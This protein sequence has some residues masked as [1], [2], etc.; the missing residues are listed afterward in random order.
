M[1]PPETD[2]RAYAFVHLFT[3]THVQ[4]EHIFALLYI[5]TSSISTFLLISTPLNSQY[6][7]LVYLPVTFSLVKGEYF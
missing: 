3:H 2:V 6:F 7:H 1:S 5:V 4:M